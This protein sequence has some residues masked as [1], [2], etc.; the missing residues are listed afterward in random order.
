MS[1]WNL[2]SRLDRVQKSALFKVVA[3]VAVTLLMAAAVVTYGVQNSKLREQLALVAPDAELTASFDEAIRKGEQASKDAV[4]SDA[5]AAA[6]VSED[7]ERAAVAASLKDQ[8]ESMTRSINEIKERRLDLTSVGIGAAGLLLVLLVI[9]WLG[10]ALTY[11]AATVLAAAAGVPL[12]GYGGPTAKSVGVFLIAA[13]GLGAAFFALIEGLRAILSASHPIASIARNVVSEAM[14]MRVSLIFIVMLVFGLASL[15]G[16]MDSEKALRYQVQSFLTY[17]VG[18]TYWLIA[19]LTVFLA[20][21]TVAFEQRD[22][23]IWQTMTK[24]VRAWEYVLGK[25]L[26]VVGVAAVLLVVSSAGCLM[27]TEYLRRQPAQGEIQPFV[28]SSPEQPISPDR[29]LLETQVLTAQS[30]VRPSLPMLDWEMRQKALEA[31]ISK[32]KADDSMFIDSADSR[33]RL[34]SDLDKEE[35]TGYFAIA[36][37]EGREYVFVGLAEARRRGAPI[38]LRYKIHAGSDMPTDNYRITLQPAGAAPFIREIRLGQVM[39]EPLSAAAVQWVNVAD[40]RDGQLMLYVFNGDLQRRTMNRETISF[41]TTDFEIAYPVGGFTAN[42]LRVVLVMWLKLA[43]LAMVGVVAGTFLSFPVAALTSFGIF[44]CAEGA[45]FLAESLEYF[46]L[47]DETGT[48]WWRYPIMFIGQGV[49]KVFGAYSNLAPVENLVAGQSIEWGTLAMSG[50]VLT[51]ATV[52]LW[53]IG[54]A[55]FRRRELAI[56]SGQ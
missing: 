26:G 27:F 25:W 5:A 14:R 28:S 19:M 16:L 9:I 13:I 3:S 4:P 40:G 2:L 41:A 15:P 33:R 6:A 32:A 51:I 53:A 46:E 7:K 30:R 39:T 45:S 1:F 22:K 20:C 10:V 11:L 42:F 37:G 56:Y 54:A 50:T 12:I 23:I 55:I 24:P 38:T 52:L 8:Y 18:G 44:L 17:G 29:L 47:G 49:S 34:V 36:P 31:R 43:F 48:F 21:A 35:I